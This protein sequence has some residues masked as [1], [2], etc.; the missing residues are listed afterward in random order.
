VQKFQRKKRKR[1]K[2]QTMRRKLSEKDEMKDGKDSDM[3]PDHHHKMIKHHMKELHKLAK[4]GHKSH[5][6]KKRSEY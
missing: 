4:K 3:H 2:E 6:K 1:N 5:H